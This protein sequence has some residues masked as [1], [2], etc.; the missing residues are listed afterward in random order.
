MQVYSIFR[1]IYWFCVIIKKKCFLKNFLVIQQRSQKSKIPVFFNEEANDLTDNAPSGDKDI[2]STVA[3]NSSTLADI[4][5]VPLLS[6][7]ISTCI[8]RSISSSLSVSESE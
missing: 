5:A 3:R 7:F 8:L 1:G 6:G 4:G 2:F